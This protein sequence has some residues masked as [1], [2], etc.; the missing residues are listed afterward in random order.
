MKGGKEEHRAQDGFTYIAF[1][2]PECGDCLLT[3]LV[4]QS[5]S[6]G[7]GAFLSAPTKRFPLSSHAQPR[8]VPHL[9]L[10]RTWYPTTTST[11]GT[12]HTPNYSALAVA[13][14]TGWAGRSMREFALQLIQRYT[15]TIGTSPMQF[16]MYTEERIPR[17]LHELDQDSDELA[18]LCINDDLVYHDRQD[19]EL[20]HQFLER[21]LPPL[22]DEV[23][24][25]L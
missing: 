11:N 9:P 22:A 13:R 1:A 24:F 17:V 23:S 7:L 10:T 18:L 4:Q 6:K 12:R 3:H 25:E 16:V 8:Q 14:S 19:I 2:H 15:Y 21:R 5:G 20:L